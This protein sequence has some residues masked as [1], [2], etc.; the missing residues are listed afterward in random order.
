MEIGI[1]LDGDIEHAFA[2]L[3]HEAGADLQPRLAAAKEHFSTAMFPEV[4]SML[5]PDPIA[6]LPPN[7]LPAGILLQAFALLRDRRYF[8]SRLAAR[9]LPFFK[10]IGSALPELSQVP[11]AQERARAFVHA[12]NDHPEGTLLE[13]ATGARYLL[14]GFEVRFIPEADRRTPDIALALIG[15]EIQ[16]ECKRLR[17]SQYE[18]AEARDARRLFAPACELAAGHNAF[19]HLD[20]TFLVP[21]GG[22]PADYLL[23]HV[24]QAL[25]QGETKY[26]WNEAAARGRIVPGDRQALQ[27][28]TD[29]SSLLVGPKLFRLFTH[30]VVPSQRV[31]MGVRGA[32]HEYDP[33]YLHD[34]EAVAVCSWDTESGESIEA[35]ARHVRSKLAEI[36]RQ[37]L[38]CQLGA[39][40]IVVDAER[41]ARAADLRRARIQEQVTTFRF[42]SNVGAITTHYLLTHTAEDRSWTIDETADYAS[43][44][45]RP[46]LTDWRLFMQ[47]EEMGDGP[48]WQLPTPVHLG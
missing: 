8:D 4:G 23:E 38:G 27:D 19:V 28:D 32:A 12:R 42:D 26:A 1:E 6:L 48:A 36:D 29:D 41:D 11:G 5:W 14:E 34:F 13:L 31:L 37:L 22:V 3:G 40:H 25:A 24:R 43:R 30:S 16:V 7:D 2:W 20:V 44:I 10:L 18:L 17:P 33:R 47:G 15:G 46:L 39:A 9:T 35:R 21:L 45:E